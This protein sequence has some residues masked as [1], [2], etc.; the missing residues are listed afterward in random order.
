MPKIE[1]FF[2]CSSPWTYLAFSRARQFAH[3]PTVDFVWRPILVGGVFNAVNQSVYAR[4]AEPDVRQQAYYLKDLQDW[5]Q[6]CG[7]KIGQPPVF[8]VR[9]VDAM[10][11]A[12]VA[13]TQGKIED[14]ADSVF[15]AYWSDLQD[16]SKKP[17]L[18]SICDQVGLDKDFFFA[19]IATEP[20]KAQLRTNTENL[21]DRGGFGSP[22]FF[23]DHENMFFGNDRIPL[24]E[25]AL[26]IGSRA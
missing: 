17:I 18:E 1:F 16:I 26:G 20:I 25:S 15:K 12:I 13:E 11:G 24:I 6:Y 19:T 23:V 14:Y 8:P 4:R 10:R 5:A 21:I 2:D 9:S 22:T 7:I 3:M